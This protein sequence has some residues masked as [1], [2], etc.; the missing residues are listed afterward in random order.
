MFVSVSVWGMSPNQ[1]DEACADAQAALPDESQTV[2]YKVCDKP[3]PNQWKSVNCVFLA[4]S[5]KCL[6]GAAFGSRGPARKRAVRV[7]PGG[8]PPCCSI[9]T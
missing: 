1:L 8:I 7:C 2:Q 4:A 3:T 5:D 6:A 9:A